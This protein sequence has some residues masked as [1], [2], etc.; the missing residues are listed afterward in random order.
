M[1]KL[2]VLWFMAVPFLGLQSSAF[3]A[4]PRGEGGKPDIM[5]MDQARRAAEVVSL[6]GTASEDVRVTRALVFVQAVMRNLAESPDDPGKAAEAAIAWLASAP[7]SE[8]VPSSG[9][10]GGYQ[11][12]CVGAMTDVLRS[13]P[14]YPPFTCLGAA[15][16][17]ALRCL[18]TFG[19]CYQYLEG[20]VTGPDR[21]LKNGIIFT[22]HS[23]VRGGMLLGFGA[24]NTMNVKLQVIWTDPSPSSEQIEVKIT[25][26]CEDPS[27][28]WDWTGS[29]SPSNWQSGAWTSLIAVPK[30]SVG[31]L[32]SRPIRLAVEVN[33][34]SD[35]NDT[36]YWRWQLNI[37]CN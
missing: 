23:I 15:I 1:R 5:S 37:D 2:L 17:S 10:G 9:S 11:P 18:F 12:P 33:Q 36:I 6:N 26:V 14:T 32:D 4:D 19:E 7:A 21:V 8:I 13:C 20:Q 29:F 28:Q 35:M 24:D 22:T 27:G 34:N 25:R 30:C 16:Q 3:A 31:V